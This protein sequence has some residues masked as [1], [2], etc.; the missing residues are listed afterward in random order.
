MSLKGQH[1]L[2]QSWTPRSNPGPAL[3][4]GEPE[5]PEFLLRWA[6]CCSSLQPPRQMACPASVVVA[7]TRH[8]LRVA[9]A[10]SWPCWVCISSARS[11]VAKMSAAF[12]G[13]SRAVVGGETPQVIC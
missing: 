10:Q 5:G 9:L 13:S 4:T 1:A 3:G 8:S 11:R 12:S 6:P 7:R 2:P